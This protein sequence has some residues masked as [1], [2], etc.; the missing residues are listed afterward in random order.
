MQKTDIPIK[1]IDSYI[2]N[3]PE[4]VR[5]VLEKLRWVIK[6]AAP[7]AEEL[8]SYSIPAFK[9]HGMLVYFAA[10][11]DH[12][13]FFPGNAGLVQ[14]MQDELKIYKTAK[15]TIQFTVEKPLPAVLVTKIVK[16]R[17]QQNKEKWFAKMKK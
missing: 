2:A 14:S 5:I 7:E 11:K 9:Y 10:F 4:K 6:K 16:A 1:D 3:Q 13:S 12:C 17:V 8:I 15:G